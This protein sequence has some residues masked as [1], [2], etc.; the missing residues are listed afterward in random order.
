M[1]VLEDVDD[2]LF[3]FPYVNLFI[4]DKLAALENDLFS[5]IKLTH[6]DSSGVARW[7]RVDFLL[8]ML[9]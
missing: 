9:S 4:A 6:V 2:G 3:W 7:I 5:C 1:L 8:N